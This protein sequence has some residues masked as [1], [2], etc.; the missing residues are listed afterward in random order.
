MKYHSF[1]ILFLFFFNPVFAQDTSK[2]IDKELKHGIQFQIGGLLDLSNFYGY[3][4]SYWYRFNKCSG[5]RIGLYTDLN[6]VDYDITQQLDSVTINPPYYSHNYN[7]KVSVQYLHSVM[8]YNNFD[9]IVGGGP[10]ISFSN[11][12]STIE[13]LGPSS[14][15]ISNSKTKS[16][17]YGFD[18]IL[19]VEYELADNVILSGEYGLTIIKESGDIEE[20]YIEESETNNYINK[21]YGDRD[22][23][24][25]RSLNVNLGLSI[26]F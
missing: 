9:L 17:S 1:L 23:L 20:E 10:F 16:T 21:Q 18:M 22:R 15:R 25:I 14:K 2:T 24:L 5:I 19:G 11:S 13:R 3:T 12:E 4:F 7:F 26:F 6:N 8:K